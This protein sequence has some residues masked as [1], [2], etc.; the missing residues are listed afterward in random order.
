MPDLLPKVHLYP[1]YRETDALN[2]GM[3]T[4]LVGLGAG[5][6]SACM[7]NAYFSTTA[8]A[9][10]VVSVYGATIPI[11]GSNTIYMNNSDL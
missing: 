10:T 8:R 5:L 6:F 2:A 3:R 9:W 7:K 1:P 4:G 11:Y